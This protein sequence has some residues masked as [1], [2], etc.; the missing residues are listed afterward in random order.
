MLIQEKMKAKELFGGKKQT[1]KP[2][3]YVVIQC[4]D[5]EVFE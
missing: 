5:S 2:K 3:T 1:A 4:N